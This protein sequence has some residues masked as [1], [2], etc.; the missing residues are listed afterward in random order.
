MVTYEIAAGGPKDY[1]VTV[2]SPESTDVVVGD[3]CSLQDAKEF[4]DR[5]REIDA[6]NSSI[7][8]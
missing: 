3:F 2:I 6:G 8:S 1:Q 7:S 4:A 5:M